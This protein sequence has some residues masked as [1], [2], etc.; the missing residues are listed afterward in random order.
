MTFMA[1]KAVVVFTRKSVETILRDG[2]TRSWRLKPDHTRQY[3]FVVC[4][5]NASDTD[6][7]RSA[8]LV[9]KIKDVLE[10][11]EKPG[12]FLIQISGYARV[13]IADAWAKGDRNPVK[14][15]TLEDLN[16]DPSTLKF[17]A[18]ATTESP[19]K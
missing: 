8:F 2:G 10:V 17:K 15:S 7:H 5:R 4:T 9:G 13:N 6:S 19:R 11:P 12:R 14:Y 16:I 3:P 1:N 18:M